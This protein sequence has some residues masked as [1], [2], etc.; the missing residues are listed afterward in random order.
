MII[1]KKNLGDDWPFTVDEV[2]I[3]WQDG[4]EGCLVYNNNVYALTGS[5]EIPFLKPL[6]QSNIWADD[7]ETGVKKSLSPLF[8]FLEAK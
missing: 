6:D 3:P 8:K 2:S 4:F 7:P 1:N 5:L